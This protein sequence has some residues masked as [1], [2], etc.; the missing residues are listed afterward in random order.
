MLKTT[1]FV[2]VSSIYCLIPQQT[3]T[4]NEEEGFALSWWSSVEVSASPEVA[5]RHVRVFT[6][7]SSINLNLPPPPAVFPPL[8]TFMSADMWALLTLHAVLRGNCG[9][10]PASAPELSRGAQTPPLL[11]SLELM[12]VCNTPKEGCFLKHEIIVL[13]YPTPIT[14]KPVWY[15]E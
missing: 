4:F 11:S 5:A 15:S 14:Q 12:H 1:T 10:N 7:V 2:L 6:S 13:W 3:H 8:L 9:R